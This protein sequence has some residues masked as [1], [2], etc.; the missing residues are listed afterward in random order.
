MPLLKYT[1]KANLKYN[2]P[3]LRPDFAQVFRKDRCDLIFIS[4]LFK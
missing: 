3:K 4:W 1:G 2:F